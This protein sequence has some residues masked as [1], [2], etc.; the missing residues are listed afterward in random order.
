MKKTFSIASL[1]LLL[2]AATVAAWL[3]QIPRPLDHFELDISGALV[4]KLPP[5]TKLRIVQNPD[6]RRTVDLEVELKDLPVKLSAL[7]PHHYSRSGC[8]VEFWTKAQPAGEQKLFSVIVDC[9]LFDK[10]RVI[11]LRLDE[12]IPE[13]N[14]EFDYWESQRWSPNLT[15]RMRYLDLPWWN[16][17]T[18]QLEPIPEM[19]ELIV[20]NAGSGKVLERSR[21]IRQECDF[22]GWYAWIADVEAKL[23][24]GDKL[25]FSVEYDSGGLFD[26]IKTE[27]LF[28]YSKDRHKL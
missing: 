6:H 13:L 2:T 24:T 18:Q 15:R 26:T 11:T 8:V 25:N 21:L 16:K 7:L 14:P 23:Q 5:D 1:L 28:K 10:F 12:P 3:L 22:D 27:E 9:E 17:T 4:E 19:P 20:T